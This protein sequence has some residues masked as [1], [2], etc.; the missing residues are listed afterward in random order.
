[1]YTYSIPMK[2]KSLTTK[3]LSSVECPTCG[4]AA[5]MRCLRYSGGLRSEP[6]IYRKLSALETVEKK[7]FPS[8]LGLSRMS[9]NESK[10]CRTSTMRFGRREGAA[11]RYRRPSEGA[12]SA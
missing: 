1:M 11:V 5:G 8:L 7:P 10:R 4:V 2:K 12:R 3:Q 6:H 9:G